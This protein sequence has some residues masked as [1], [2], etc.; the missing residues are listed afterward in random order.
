MIKKR[1]FFQSFYNS[2]GNLDWYY[3]TILAVGV[4]AIFAFLAELTGFFICFEFKRFIVSLFIS[5]ENE[6][7]VG[8][9]HYM[10]DFKPS[11]DFFA[12]II[13]L[14]ATL[15]SIAIPITI[16]NVADSLKPYKDKD[17]RQMFTNERTFKQMIVIII[18]LACA[19]CIWFFILKNFITGFVLLFLG[20]LALL[21]FYQFIRR[22]IEYITATDDVVLDELWSNID[23]DFK[24]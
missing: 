16:T 9:C 19:L 13:G 6:N 5:E 7:S 18:L 8:F 21:F 11:E 4:F 24:K 10:L 20:I 2:A 3:L 1:K 23:K 14:L 12:A 15:I 17:I 22:V